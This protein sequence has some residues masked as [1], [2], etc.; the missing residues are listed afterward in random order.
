MTPI[1]NGLK[2]SQLGVALSL[3]LAFC[4][5]A[6]AVSAQPV[7]SDTAAAAAE[8]QSEDAAIAAID[9]FIAEENVDK[10]RRAWKSTLAKP[11]KVSFTAGKSYFWNLETN[12]GKIQI[13]LMP[14][15]APMHVSSTIYL[16][17]LGFYDDTVFHRVI[18]GFMAQGGDPTG[19]GRG[20]PGYKYDGEFD[21]TVK[22]D[23]A[24][25]LSM[26]NAGPGTDGSQFFLTFV[27][28]P[29]LNGK[30]TIFGRVIKGM[31]TV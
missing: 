19:T 25:L 5:A 22:H 17:R 30:H 2:S 13:K 3:A 20:G 4:F 12:K 27:K 14:D 8:K 9:A 21:R 16:T 18:P 31:D 26:A 29:H 23:K 1:R 10:A 11:P 7:E 15:V 28:T 24:G 6:L